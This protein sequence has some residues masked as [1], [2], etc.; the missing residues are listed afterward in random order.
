MGFLTR[1]LAASPLYGHET[2]DD[3][4]DDDD[5]HNDPEGDHIHLIYLR[6]YGNGT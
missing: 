1:G 5:A 3:E 4:E 6:F 2:D